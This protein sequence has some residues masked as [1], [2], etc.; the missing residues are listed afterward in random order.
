M[1]HKLAS[2]LIVLS[3]ANIGLSA[4]VHV[5]VMSALFGDLSHVVNVLVGLA[6]LY[7]LLSNYTTLLRKA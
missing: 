5:D 1:W 2:L 4:I 3:A 6:G 7:M